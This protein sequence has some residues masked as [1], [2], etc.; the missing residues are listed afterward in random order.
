MC[1][2]MMGIRERNLPSVDGALELKAGASQ[3]KL[4]TDRSKIPAAG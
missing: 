2:R 4:T 1:R 3:L